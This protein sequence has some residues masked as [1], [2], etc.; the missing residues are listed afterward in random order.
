MTCPFCSDVRGRKIVFVGAALVSLWAASLTR[1]AVIFSDPFNYTDGALVNVSGGTWVHHSGTT[2]GEVQVVSA[3]TFIS[4]TNTEDVSV[5]LPGQPYYSTNNTVLYASFTVNFRSLPTGNNGT[6]FGHF[7]DPGTTGFRDKI[8]VTTNGAAAGTFRFGL[9]N[10]DNSVASVFL[11]TN[12]NVNTDYVLVTRYV[13]SN[14]TS[15][16]WLNPGA[17][18]DPGISAT[19]AATEIKMTSFAL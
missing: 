10:A 18:S 14:A 12:L 19:D 4:Q 6:Y 1:A 16:L 2:T 3:R 5:Q 13:L 15:T 7:K 8:Y 11:T 17:E 9:A